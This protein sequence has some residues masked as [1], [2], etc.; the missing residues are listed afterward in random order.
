MKKKALLL[1]IDYTIHD[2]AKFKR[3]LGKDIKKLTNLSSKKTYEIYEKVL[4]KYRYFKPD[5]FI[6]ILSKELGNK[7][8]KEL[9]KTLIFNERFNKSIYSDTKLFLK[10]ISNFVNIYIFS[11]GD[12]KFQ[13]YKFQPLLKLVKFDKVIILKNKLNK[14]S[15]IIKNLKE[16]LIFVID[17][18]PFVIN[19]SKKVSKRIVTIYIH[20]YNGK[21]Y[22]F[23]TPILADY[24]VTNL[25]SA[26]RIIQSY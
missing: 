18:S 1:D 24:K 15:Q 20:R 17:D 23:K 2:N 19:A 12:K 21:K 9:N 26:A 16:N 14:I 13:E 22:I 6:N 3:L 11:K 8:N 25:T 4:I 10:K 7:Y 5:A